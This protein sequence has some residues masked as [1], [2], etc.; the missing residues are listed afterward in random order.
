MQGKDRVILPLDVDSAEQAVE[1]VKL[2]RN[3]VGAFKVGLELLN[4]AGLG[5]FDQISAAGAARIFYD[6]KFHDIPNTVAGAC[7]AAAR[8]GLWLV[9][10]HCSGGTAMMAAAKAAVLDEG[11]RQGVEPPKV[12][13]VTVLTSIDRE[14]LN[15]QMRVPGPVAEQVVH[16]ARLAKDA[17]LAGVV[18]SPCEIDAIR[19]ACGSDFLIVT[20]GVRPAGAELGDQKRVMTPGEAV[21]RGADYLVIGRPIIKAEDP[22][23]A[24][25]RIAE[26]IDHAR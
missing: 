11:A 16:L 26:E 13:G 23:M 1:L 3:D 21:A 24:A 9:N 17:G 18:A 22:V 15:T 12:I 25:R 14:T 19:A 6:A 2:L 7:R 4:S 8:L 5:V 10:V 20:P